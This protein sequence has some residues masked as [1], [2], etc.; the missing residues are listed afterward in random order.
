VAV[1]YSGDIVVVPTDV[2]SSD[3]EVSAGFDDGLGGDGA[4][5]GGKSV[6]V[7]LRVGE[8]VVVLVVVILDRD[9]V[10]VDIVELTVVPDGALDWR[11]VCTTANTISATA[12]IPATPAATITP[13]RSCHG[14]G[15]VP[16]SPLVTGLDL[17]APFWP[18]VRGAGRP[19]GP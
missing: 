7:E 12:T 15:S 13:G 16:L 4:S 19:T 14:R 11:D 5:G 18:P 17:R 1:G 3:S 6:A 9:V 10:V 8:Y 2:E